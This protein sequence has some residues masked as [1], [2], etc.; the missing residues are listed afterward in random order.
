L[1]LPTNFAIAYAFNYFKLLASH[2]ISKSLTIQ[3]HLYWRQI[4]HSLN[5]NFFFNCLNGL[6]FQNESFLLYFYLNISIKLLDFV[7]HFDFYL[8]SFLKCGNIFFII[9]HA[10]AQSFLSLKYFLFNTP[11]AD[12][13]WISKT[14][15]T[16]KTW[17]TAFK[18]MLSAD[19]F[20]A[21][22]IFSSLYLFIL[23][24]VIEI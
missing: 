6:E 16:L 11:V 12:Q 3:M 20:G 17:M 7:F 13:F 8:L 4:F 10:S 22:F 24:F 19:S 23:I 9:D 21:I 2:L 15:F 14:S 5:K 1:S 18:L